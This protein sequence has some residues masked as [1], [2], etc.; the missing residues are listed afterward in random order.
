MLLRGSAAR[1][2]R[3]EEAILAALWLEARKLAPWSIVE[4]AA[5]A[6]YVRKQQDSF[7]P[8][9]RSSVLR[10]YRI[11]GF[12]TTERVL[13]VRRFV[14][15]LASVFSHSKA[16]THRPGRVRDDAG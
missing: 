15:M 6:A 9:V 2:R 7:V 12:A 3:A 16:S 1:T 14:R 10:L 11:L 13:Q 4:A 5:L 8:P